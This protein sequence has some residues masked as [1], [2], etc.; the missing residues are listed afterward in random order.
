MN[1]ASLFYIKF[2]F[3]TKKIAVALDSW[4]VL[5]MP[6]KIEKIGGEV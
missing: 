3:R 4:K 5:G 2:D 6:A 1:P